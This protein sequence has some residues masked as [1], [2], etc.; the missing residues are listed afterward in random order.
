PHDLVHAVDVDVRIDG[1][2]QAHAL[3]TRENCPQEIALPPLFNPIP[4]ANLDDAATPIGHRIRNV[5]VL[6]NAGLQP[7][8]ELEDRRL[9]YGRVD[10]AVVRHV[11]A[12]RVDERLV[13]S[14]A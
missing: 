5:D 14:G 3:R 11:D 13:R 10:V 6:D 12:Q 2:R 4:L 9:T 7:L 8:A 1:D